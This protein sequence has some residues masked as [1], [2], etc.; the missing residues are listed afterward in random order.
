MKNMKNIIKYIMGAAALLAAASCAKNVNWDEP[1]PGDGQPGISLQFT[2]SALT[3]K[4]TVPGVN[5]ENRVDRIRFFVFPATE[6]QVTEGEGENATTKTV[7]TVADDAE[8]IFSGSYDGED[9]NGWTYT[10]ATESASEK[11]VYA[12][13]MTTEELQK[14]FP[15][16][17]THAKVFAVANYVGFYGSNNSMAHPDT[18]FPEDKKTWKEL[19]DIEVGATFFYDDGTK[20]FGLR[21]PHV[22]RPY[23]YTE[24]EGESTVQKEDN[25]FFVMTSE[26]DLVLNK[27]DVS[28]ADCPLERL[29]SKVTATF[30][31]DN[32]REVKTDGTSTK[33]IMWIPQE[34]AG[35]TRVYLS[36]AIEHTTLGGPL[37]RSYKEDSWANATK[38]LGN[39]TRDIFEYAYN[40]MN[41]VQTVDGKK[42]AHFYTYPIQLENG[43]DNQPYLKLVLPW[44][45]YKWVGEGTAPAT[46]EGDITTNPDWMLYKQKEVY[47]KIVLPR[48]TISKPNH[49]YEFTVKVNIIGSDKEVKIIGEQYVVKDWLSDE[50]ISSNVATGRYISLELPKDEYDMY[51]D[52]I[53]INFVSSGTV[54][55]QIDSIYQLNY[56]EASRVT[57]DIFML[58]SNVPNTATQGNPSLLGRKGVTVD[59]VKGWVTIP[60]NTSYLE[61]NHTM[62]NRMLINNAK[63]PAFDM[64][65][66]V[67][68]ITLHL[69]E[70]GD[71]TAFDRTLTITQYPALYVSNRVSNGYTFVNKTGNADSGDVDCYDDGTNNNRTFLGNISNKAGSLS[72]TGDNENPNNY[73]ITT[74]MVSGTN[75]ILGDP[76][77]TTVNN[78]SRL[79]LT[80]YYPTAT[81]GTRNMIAPKLLI[82]SSYGVQSGYQNGSGGYVTFEGAQKRCA[83]YQENGYP[84]GRWRVPTFAEIDFMMTLSNAGF[85]PSLFNLGRNDGQ[86]YWCANG[87]LSG[88]ANGYPYISNNTT[89][90]AVRCVYDAWYWG[91]EPYQEGA[92]EWLGYHDN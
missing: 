6:T 58:D 4:A 62:D 65:P 72:G 38:P 28:K 29:A 82:A 92:T 76:R 83:S 60:Q 89:R 11:W 26:A 44:I 84:A 52:K 78:F 90:T 23:K 79:A 19:H 9:G 12:K 24:G 5:Q 87:K 68:K 30:T 66:Y 36:N 3:T 51:V 75:Y 69:V 81:T 47:Y 88:D 18:N 13:T 43:D 63:N 34:N 2:N 14:L 53:D 10:A 56:S 37:N 39:G 31:Y 74:S 59:D 16:G 42:V 27:T 32:Y 64:A 86:G 55:A 70:A 41:D 15:N 21:W 22:M 48:E 46:V 61:I 91:E 1:V 71:D 50:A 45:G 33:V 35:E 77:S 67:Y 20:D 17:A 73:I 40:F 80:N 85:I 25:L 57:K 7:Y 8:Y 49:I 54:V